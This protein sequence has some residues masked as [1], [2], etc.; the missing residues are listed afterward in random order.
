MLNE[1]EKEWREF[2]LSQLDS[3][4][5]QRLLKVE[6]QINNDP[7]RRTRKIMQTRSDPTSAHARRT[8]QLKESNIKRKARANV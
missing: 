1:S 6:E 7:N 8:R 3:E 4:Q 5:T 2:L